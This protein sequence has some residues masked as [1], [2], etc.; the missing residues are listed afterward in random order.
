MCQIAIQKQNIQETHCQKKALI[1]ETVDKIQRY[2]NLP[3]KFR[4]KFS[5]NTTSIP[6]PD[7]IELKEKLEQRKQQVLCAMNSSKS[8][9]F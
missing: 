6:S 2:T 3:K 5:C 7:I 9:A 1:C 8:S 4:S